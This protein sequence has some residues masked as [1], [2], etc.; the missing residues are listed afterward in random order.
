MFFYRLKLL[1]CGF[2]KLSCVGKCFRQDA[3]GKFFHHPFPFHD[4]GNAV[5]RGKRCPESLFND[6]H[7]LRRRRSANTLVPFLHVFCQIRFLLLGVPRSVALPV[8]I[9]HLINARMNASAAAAGGGEGGGG[10]GGTGCRLYRGVG[11]SSRASMLPPLCLEDCCLQAGGPARKKDR[12]SRL[13][14]RTTWFGRGHRLRPRTNTTTIRILAA[15]PMEGNKHRLWRYSVQQ[16]QA[17]LTRE[18]GGDRRPIRVRKARNDE[19]HN[20]LRVQP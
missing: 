2:N 15:A 11:K 12:S 14:G 18:D 10:G 16:Q 20:P 5:G 7:R 4:R 8:Q 17:T 9:Q 13:L 1:R 6:A 3:L 19:E